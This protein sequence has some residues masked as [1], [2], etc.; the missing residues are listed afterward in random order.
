MSQDPAAARG[1]RFGVFEV[2]CA[3]AALTKGG[4]TVR[5]RGKP[6]DILVYLLERPG[7]LVTRDELR[8]HLWTADTFVDFDHGLNAAMNRLRDALGDTAE[9]PRF[10]QTMP[11]RG[12]RFIA[13]VQR[14]TALPP[15]QIAPALPAPAPPPRFRRPGHCVPG[16]GQPLPA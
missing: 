5:L 11:R 14:L 15:P 16:P 7:D 3:A 12:Y 4:T 1:Y 8:A 2:E 10:I 9:N 13:P 6:F